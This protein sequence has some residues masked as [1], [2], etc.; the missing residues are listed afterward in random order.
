MNEAPIALVI[1]RSENGTIGRDG[2][3]PW[4]MKSD[5]KW[6]K[7]VTMGKPVVMGRKTY[8][9]IGKALPGRQ[10][11]VVTRNES[12]VPEDALTCD[13]IRSALMAARKDLKDTGASEICIIGGGT[14]YAQTLPLADRLYLTT[15]EE[16]I[17]GDVRFAEPDPAAWQVKPVR[18]IRKSTKDDYDA[19]L[20]IW[21]RVDD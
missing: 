9:S 21:E 8:E 11:I 18:R 5:L 2:A 14:I 6:F 10:N 17:D 1:A 3:L 16:R 13:S 15:I 4:R 7:D 19:R 20:E 12:F